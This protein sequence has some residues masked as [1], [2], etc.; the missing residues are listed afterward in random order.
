M[1]LIVAVVILVCRTVSAGVRR[2]SAVR[3]HVRLHGI[4]NA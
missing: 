4:V 1:L 3:R 2:I